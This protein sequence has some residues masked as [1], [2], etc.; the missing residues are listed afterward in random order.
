MS[1]QL[2]A[3]LRQHPRFRLLRLMRML[4]AAIHLQLAG[5]LLAQFGLGQHARHRLLDDQFRLAVKALAEIFRPQATG[6][7]GVMVI[8]LLFRLHARD[9]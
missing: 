3:V 7:P 1:P 4:V 5:H 6:I 2:E 9:A 8:H